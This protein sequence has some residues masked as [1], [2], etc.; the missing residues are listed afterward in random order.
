MIQVRLVQKLYANNG[1]L[2]V[3]TCPACPEQYDVFMGAERV[4]YLRLRS[5]IFTVEYKQ[6]MGER[7]LTV[8]PEGDGLFDRGERFR[9]LAMALRIIQKKIEESTHFN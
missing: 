3:M 9:Y 6:C 5:Q 1:F 8:S 7:L 4:A 2:L